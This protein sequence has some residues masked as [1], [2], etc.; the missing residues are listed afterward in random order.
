MAR[1]FEWTFGQDAD[2]AAWLKRSVQRRRTLQLLVPLLIVGL[3]FTAFAGEREQ[4]TLRQLLSLGVPRQVLARGKAIA[5]VVPLAVILIPATAAGALAMAFYSG[6]DGMALS[7]SR[8]GILTL[9]YL[10]YFAIWVGIGLVVSARARSSRAALIV[11][12]TLWFANG[13]IAPRLAVSAARGVAPTPTAVAFAEA[14]E[15]D[16]AALTPWDDLVTQA[17]QELL[18]EHGVDDVKQ[19]PVNPEGVALVR[20]EAADTAVHDRH[21]QNLA[22]VH[23]RQAALYQGGAVLA[24]LVAV[25]SLSMALAGTDYAHYRDFLDAA[26]RYRTRYVEILNADVVAHQKPDTWAYTRGRDLWAQV[27]PFEYALPGTGWALSHQS[28]SLVLLGAWAVALALAVP[29]ALRR[30]RVD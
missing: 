26:E 12:L 22:G 3:T 10:T 6:L 18:A 4:G 17:R 2:H 29:A 15:R 20:G 7:L 9:V 19:L 13:F 16:K 24:P 28:A 21:F 1:A 27:P 8:A 14:I 30:V 25:Q 5:V 11:L 23:T